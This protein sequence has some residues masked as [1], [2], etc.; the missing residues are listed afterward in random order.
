MPNISTLE[1]TCREQYGI[2]FTEKVKELIPY[3]WQITIGSDLQKVKFV[4]LIENLFTAFKHSNEN[5]ISLCE[6]I[7]DRLAFTGQV[8][9]LLELL[10]TKYDDPLQRIT[11]T[12]LNNNFLEGIDIYRNS[13][14]DPTPIEL[15]R[16]SENPP[17]AITLFTNAEII[18]SGSLV[19]KSFIIN[20]PVSVP[21]NDQIIRALLAFYVIAP[22]EYLINRF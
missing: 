6:F 10:N 11:I 13:E 1:R 19:G 20:I 7:R 8:L 2:D 21:T 17:T 5:F 12:C 14:T 15:Y 18:D 22:Q 9:S 3:F 16:N 4:N